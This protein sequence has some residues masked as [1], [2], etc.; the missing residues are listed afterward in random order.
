MK[1]ELQYGAIIENSLSGLKFKPEPF[2]TSIWNQEFEH[3]DIEIFKKAVKKIRSTFKEFPTYSDVREMIAQIKA[4]EYANRQQESYTYET[5]SKSRKVREVFW[6]WHNW[7]G[8]HKKVTDKI[9]IEY[10]TGVGKDYMALGGDAQFMY[11][12]NKL[13]AN[14]DRLERGEEAE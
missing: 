14:A 9:L 7:L 11:E 2:P 4:E 3:H 8:T 1:K 12:V 10:Y 6:K 5:G 13:F